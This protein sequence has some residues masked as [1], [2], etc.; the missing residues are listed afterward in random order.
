MNAAEKVKNDAKESMNAAEKVKN[1]AKESM[2]AAGIS[3]I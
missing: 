3:I 2:N 1:Y